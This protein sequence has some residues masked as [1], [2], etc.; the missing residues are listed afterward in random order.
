MTVIAVTNESTAATDS[1]V[2]LITAAV[3]HQVR[4]HFAPHWGK[5]ASLVAVPKGGKPPSGAWVVHVKDTSDQAG[6]LGY[7][8]QEGNPSAYAFALTDKQAGALLSVTISHEVLEML[9][10]PNISRGEQ[11]TTS[12]WYALEVGDPVEAD[13]DGYQINGVTVSDFILE[14]W[15]DPRAPGPYDYRGLL[16]KPLGVRPGGYVSIWKGTGG[17]AQYQA[18]HD[19]SLEPEPPD[20]ADPRFRPRS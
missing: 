11:V 19:G 17:W 6:A 8:D 14:A 13:T 15:F 2:A 5:S 4:Y 7:H 10:D 18:Q 9:A 1:E 3:A 20:P 16:T 12:E